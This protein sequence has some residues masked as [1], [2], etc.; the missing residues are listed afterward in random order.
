MSLFANIFRRSVRKK[1]KRKRTDDF[2]DDEL[3]NG[4]NFNRSNS[5]RQSLTNYGGLQNTVWTLTSEN[6]AL[7]HQKEFASRRVEY[8]EKQTNG[9]SLDGLRGVSTGD[10]RVIEE[11][12]E[13]ESQ[14]ESLKSR[15][16][17]L[18]QQLLKETRDRTQLEQTVSG[19]SMYGSPV[20]YTIVFK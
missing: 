1:S 10:A 12:L 14:N 8:L 11:R 6:R 13:I 7:R 5:V 20:A 9:A 16:V 18:E 2:D 15:C 17:V 4:E 3:G 19:P